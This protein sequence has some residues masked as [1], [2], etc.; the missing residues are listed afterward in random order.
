M[1]PTAD[2]RPTASKRVRIDPET[3]ERV[4]QRANYRCEW[5]EGGTVCGLREGDIDPVGG[6]K[7]KLTPDHKRPHMTDYRSDPEDPDVWQ[8]LCGRHQIVKKNYWD[9]ITG[10]LNVYAIVQAAS[11]DEKRKVYEFLKEYFGEK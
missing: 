11:E 6:G 9:D 10:R 2:R 5:Q 4:L 7:V 8:A 3:W 1:M